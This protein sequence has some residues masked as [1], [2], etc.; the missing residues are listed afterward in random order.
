MALEPIIPKM[1]QKGDTIA[2]ISPSAR[3]NLLLPAPLQRA[4][5]FIE[6]L[7][8]HV[9]VIFNSREPANLHE[10]MLQRC[11]EIHEAFRDT[12]IKAIIC[13]VGG[14]HANEL[15]R[16]LDYQ[17]IKSHPKIFC[18]YSD[19]T[20]LHYAIL[21]QTGLQTFYGPTTFTDFAD[22]PTPFQFTI[23]QFLH[24]LQSSAGKAIGHVPRSPEYAEDL[25]DFF[26]G[27]Q[28]SQ[29]ARGLSPSP[30]WRWLRE[31]SATGRILGGCLPS[32]LR[33]TGTPFWPAHRGCILFLETPMGEDMKDPFSLEKTRSCMADLVNAGVIDEIRGL[34]VGRPYGYDEKMREEFAQ[35]IADQCY[36]ATFPILLNVDIGHTA[37]ILTLPIN[38][39]VCI[40]SSK[41]E[42]SI[43]EPSVLC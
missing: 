20:L 19:I 3:L 28:Y 12:S 17:L 40:D 33:L 32:L 15:L 1:L 9:K 7:G 29:K 35:L 34:V 10:S 14:S 18:G 22:V 6:G 36:G 42:F 2:F 16:H 41:D 30:A 11:E 26:F 39:M 43:L 37:P 8:Y 13:N 38:A 25:P 4:K 21:S 27:N 31:G 5:A 23:D 24:V